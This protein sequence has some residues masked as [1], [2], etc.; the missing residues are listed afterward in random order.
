MLFRKTRNSI[1]GTTQYLPPYAVTRTGLLRKGI[2]HACAVFARY[3]P[4]WL[5]CRAAF[6]DDIDAIY[7]LGLQTPTCLAC[8]QCRGCPA[9]QPDHVRPETMALGKWETK[10]GRTLYPFEMDDTHLVNS[11]AKLKRD[12]THFKDRWEE[13]VVILENEARLRGMGT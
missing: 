9:C 6:A 1:F 11:I 12:R 7:R 8:V 4:V 13:W 5:C 3:N 2:T 10:D